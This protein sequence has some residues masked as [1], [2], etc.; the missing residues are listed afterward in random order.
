MKQHQMRKRSNPHGPEGFPD[1][2]IF[3]S[4]FVYSCKS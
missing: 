2:L 1:A 4:A 3:S